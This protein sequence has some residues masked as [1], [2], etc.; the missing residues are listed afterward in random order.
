MAA[1]KGIAV[2]LPNEDAIIKALDDDWATVS[3]IRSRIRSPT[4][5]PQIARF[6]E[7]MA[8]AGLIERKLE[9]TIAAKHNRKRSFMLS[10]YRRCPPRE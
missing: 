7:R 3:K 5:S 2:P 9:K 10:L 1:P 4:P 8:E 6:L